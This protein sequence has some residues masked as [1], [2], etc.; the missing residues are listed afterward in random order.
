MNP[1]D[2]HEH[3][4]HVDIPRRTTASR[5]EVRRWTTHCTKRLI[6]LACQIVHAPSA[7]IEFRDELTE[8]QNASSPGMEP[9]DWFFSPL[10]RNLS[11]RLKEWGIPIS[12]ND[13][14][15]CSWAG[16]E[17]SRITTT[18]QGAMA[19]LGIPL[20]SPQGRNLGALW[21]IDTVPRTWTESDIALLSDLTLMAMAELQGSHRP[22]QEYDT[23]KEPPAPQAE[24]RGD[25]TS[26]A[27]Q[28][29][30]WSPLTLVDSLSSRIAVLDKTGTIIAVNRAWK[31]FV[32][33]SP[34]HY[35]N[36]CE[37]FNYLDVCDR[38][39][40]EHAN[41][42]A[43]FAEGI[44]RILAGSQESI[45]HEY[46]CV[47]K[48]EKR[49]F[50]AS[51]NLLLSEGSRRAVISHQDVT[52][53]KLAKEEQD[54]FFSISHEPLVIV[55]FDGR[56]RHVNA[57]VER[58]FGYSPEEL[59]DREYLTLIHPDDLKAAYD[60][61]ANIGQRAPVSNYECRCLHKNGTFR[62][63][64][65]M[66]VLV[67]EEKALYAAGRDITERKLAEEEIRRLNAQLE[68]RLERLAALRLIDMAITST[69]DS[70]QTLEILLDQILTQ[71]QVDAAAVLLYN[72]TTG[73]LEYAAG[74]GFR[75]SEVQQNGPKLGEGWASRSVLNS[76]GAIYVLDLTR[77]GETLLPKQ[78]GFVTCSIVPLLAKGQI[79]GVLEVFQRAPSATDSEW[80]EYLETLAGQAAIAI[81]N[82]SLFENLQR[83]N[84][85][86]MIAYDA[87]IEGWSHAL[88]LRDRETEGHAR[89]VTELTL[90]LA[91][92]MGVNNSE[93]MHIRRGA[94]LHDIGKMGIPDAIL[95]KPGPLDEREQEIMQRHPTY[96]YEMLRSIPFLGAAIEIPYCHHEKWD[97]TGYP[98]GL[99]GEEIPLS[100]RIFAIADIW[101]ALCSDRPYRKGWPDQQV[102]EHIRSLSGNHLDPDVV[103]TFLEI[104]PQEMSAARAE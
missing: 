100:A 4:A 79:K 98:Q 42:A 20:T 95:H 16:A 74:K 47:V 99:R 97:G 35:A 71:L 50:L 59:I 67:P 104:I 46:P 57:A 102:L 73:D 38:A 93:L 63:F 28:D 70:R 84:S 103:R 17:A 21:V 91:R 24:T 55:G 51:V 88:D 56:V 33:M 68:H 44:R 30:E 101:D 61:L 32:A 12:I 65:W 5:E 23:S 86:L 66:S 27:T 22:E 53:Q 39:A 3:T 45:S 87:T 29:Q 7:F 54:R 92:A 94:L 62:W 82:A 75:T 83:S 72:R 9:P 36:V 40:R 60:G 89:R 90:R 8:W 6:R 31:D 15:N 96:A 25:P 1:I 18:A 78:E 69:L 19:C 58:T 37:G 80:S 13:L 11:E 43:K 26:L 41:G 34:A 2:V 64:S 81:D 52:E 10:G 49:W 85:E 48:G 14:G 76:S 77:P